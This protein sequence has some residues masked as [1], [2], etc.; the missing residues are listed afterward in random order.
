MHL[1][2][3]I[4]IVAIVGVLL[5][6]GLFV[7]HN[8][9]MLAAALDAATPGDVFGEIC[10][11][12]KSGSIDFPG[13]DRSG[14][15]LRHCPD[16]LHFAG[17]NAVLPIISLPWVAPYSVASNLY[18]AIEIPPGDPRAFWPPSRAPPLRT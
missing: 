8:A 7:R 12:S 11:A 15:L 16:C 14:D 3:L 6:A 17:G 4:G 5:H 9:M 10:F 2:R 18:F 13:A 1:R